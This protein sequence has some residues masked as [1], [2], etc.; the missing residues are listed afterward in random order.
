[1]A[2]ITQFIY[3]LHI[4]RL[5][6]YVLSKNPTS[7]QNAITLAKRKDA[8]LHIIEGLHNHNSDHEVNNIYNKQN[9][10]ENNMGPCH[11][12]RAHTL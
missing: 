3:N 9:N 7:V 8:E 2:H 11:A 5:E 6:H 12:L 1:M 4:Q 10:N